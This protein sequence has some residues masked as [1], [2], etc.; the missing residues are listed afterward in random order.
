MAIAASGMNAHRNLIAWQECR[1][2]VHDIYDAT[3]GFPVDEKFGLVSQLRRAA[4]SAAS[5]I[6]EGYTR[7]GPRET[8]HGLSMALG[9]LGEIDTLFAV[10]EDLGYLAE[11]RLA[12]LEASLERASK[13]T[14][15]LLRKVRARAT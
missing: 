12:L 15:G 7:I 1:K 9:S 8:G 11:E 5:N 2:L 13:L 6:A 14:S 10:S 4:V 3:R